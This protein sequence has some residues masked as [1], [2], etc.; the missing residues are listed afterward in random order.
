MIA[1]APLGHLSYQMSELHNSES[2]I[3]IKFPSQATQFFHL[4]FFNL[5][6][7][8]SLNKLGFMTS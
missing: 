6:M 2:L 7:T 8:P 3:N 5:A 1:S 4:R